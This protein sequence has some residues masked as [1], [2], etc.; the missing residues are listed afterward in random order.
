M[1]VTVSPGGGCQSPSKVRRMPLR[2]AAQGRCRSFNGG[3]QAS[4]G[5]GGWGSVGEGHGWNV[6]APAAWRGGLAQGLEPKGMRKWSSQE[7][8]TPGEIRQVVTLRGGGEAWWG[9]EHVY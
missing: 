3:G 2:R 6:G 8:G 4:N 7:A 9:E 5:D 1:W